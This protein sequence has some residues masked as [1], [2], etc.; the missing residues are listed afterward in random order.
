MW[1][2]CPTARCDS[3][4]SLAIVI[5]LLKPGART[6]APG[7]ILDGG[8]ALEVAAE[9]GRL[10]IKSLSLQNDECYEA[11]GLRCKKA[12]GLAAEEGHQVIVKLLEEHAV[13]RDLEIM[14]L[15]PEWPWK[16]QSQRNERISRGR[17]R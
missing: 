2:H 11:N 8:T 6:S 4:L 15:N 14:S 16:Q 7:A 10:D 9:H 3:R 13:T 1:Y 17:P 5:V 12:A